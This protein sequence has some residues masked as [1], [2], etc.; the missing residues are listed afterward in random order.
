MSL[1]ETSSLDRSEDD[2]IFSLFK[3][4]VPSFVN[5]F[6]VV[7]DIHVCL[8]DSAG[9]QHVGGIPARKSTGTVSL[10]WASHAAAAAASSA[11]KFGSIVPDA[12]HGQGVRIPLLLS[13]SLSLFLS[14]HTHASSG[15]SEP[16]ALKC[17]SPPSH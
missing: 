6:V 15:L 8:C 9:L 17:P 7:C 2:I 11:T 12:P 4:Y 13:R 10:P 3:S 1:E 14:V 5:F 16:I